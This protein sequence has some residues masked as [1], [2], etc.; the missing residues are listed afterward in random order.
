MRSDISRGVL[1]VGAGPT[2]LALA[3]E[4]GRHGVRCRV[5]DRAP[6]P[7]DKSKAI[8]IQA[9][10][11]ELLALA[12]LDDQFTT[13][14][15]RVVAANVY[16]GAKRIIR[17]SFAELESAYPFLLMLPQPD[18]EH[19]LEERARSLGARVERGIELLSLGQTHDA[20]TVELRHANGHIEYARESWL[21]AC[22]GAHSTVREQLGATFE[23]HTAGQDFIVADVRMQWP[24]SSD[25]ANIF[26]DHGHVFAGFPLPENRYRIVANHPPASTA[27]ARDPTLRECQDIV[28]A[29]VPFPATLSDPRWTA[30]FRVNTRMVKQFRHGRVFLAGDAAHIHGPAGGQGMNTGIQ[31]AFNLAWKLALVERGADDALLDSYQAERHPVDRDV[32][33][34]TD[35]LLEVAS[36][37]NRFASLLRNHVAPR[38]VPFSFV[39]R[40]MRQKVSEISVEYEKSWLVEEHPLH[41][42]PRAGDR[43]PDAVAAPREGGTPINVIDACAHPWFTLLLLTDGKAAQAERAEAVARTAMERHGGCVTALTLC[44]AGASPAAAP[45]SGSGSGSRRTAALRDIY[46]PQRPAAYVIR[47]DGYVGFRSLL[48]VDGESAL[49]AYLDRLMCGSGPPAAKRFE[50]PPL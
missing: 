32:L 27:A 13:R 36:S 33:R 20:V 34:F 39:Q 22:D 5:I 12:R 46:G 24:L 40:I 38:I 42:G 47:P 17:V 48:D 41:G 29:R 3:A 2:G 14:G 28:D 4:L 16:S 21:V 23:G 10:T 7:S 50:I 35:L 1:I 43:A 8:A 37:G 44:D 45:E 11:L 9:R 49:M 6:A 31:D 18:T 25:E 19:I 30:S 26:A 15:C